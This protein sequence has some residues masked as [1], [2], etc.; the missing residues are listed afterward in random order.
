MCSEILVQPNPKFPLNHSRGQRV[1]D[2]GV[3]HP[4]RPLSR[5]PS[6]PEGPQ[7]HEKRGEF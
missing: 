3:L 4:L 7:D 6:G 5:T 2:Y 1:E